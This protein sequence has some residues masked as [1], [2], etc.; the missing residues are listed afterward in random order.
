[1]LLRAAA[2][3]F[4]T[5]T[6]VST[7]S[8]NLNKMPPLTLLTPLNTNLDPFLTFCGVG[9]HDFVRIPLLNKQPRIVLLDG[10]QDTQVNPNNVINVVTL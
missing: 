5:V 4:P 8:T 9:K 1:M 3:T 7:E 10:I 2:V 6:G